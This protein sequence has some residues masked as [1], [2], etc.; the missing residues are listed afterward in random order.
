MPDRAR[1]ALLVAVLVLGGL[2]LVWPP[3]LPDADV[4]RT[5]LLLVRAGMLLLLP[6]LAVVLLARP[7]DG[8]GPLQTLCLAPLVSLALCPLLLFWT[9]L[10][11]GVWSRGATLALLAV[12][13]G[14]VGM[15]VMCSGHLGVVPKGGRGGRHGPSG[16]VPRMVRCRGSARRARS[17]G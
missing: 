11:G 13:G 7:L 1:K 3:A 8:S 14:V 4:L 5:A 15:S 9:G 12:S 6:G 10:L 16:A 2:L 17:S